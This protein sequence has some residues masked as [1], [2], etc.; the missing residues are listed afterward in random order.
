MATSTQKERVSFAQLPQLDGLRAICLLSIVI[1]HWTVHYIKIEF[2]FEIGAFVFF[3]LSG[4]LITRILL[5]GKEKI[6]LGQSSFSILL[7]TFTIRRVLRLLPGYYLALLLYVILLTP[8]V[9]QN[10][11][12]YVTNSTNIHFA[13]MG[14]WAG[15]ADQFWTLAV[16]QQ[17]YAILP[18]IVLLVPNR[19]LP[20]VFIIIAGL[21]PLSRFMTYFDNP[22]FTGPKHDKL[23]WFLTDHLC[24]G[25]LLAYFHE[26]GKLPR[27]LILWTVLV[28]SLMLFI[29]MRYHL[30]IFEN[31]GKVFI[32]Q[33]TV[34]ATF[35][36]CLVA[37]C[38]KGIG[39]LGKVVLEHP[40]I[41]YVGKRSYGYYL[42]HNLAFLLLGKTFFFLFPT[43]AE[44]DPFFILR[45]ILAS[46]ILYFMTHFSWKYVEEPL[47][48][49]K[50]KHRYLKAN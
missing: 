24:F 25:A 19:F 18:F 44:P 21:S 22:L 23:P 13:L 31:A 45:I 50:Q 5:R 15:G 14:K 4:Y 41:Q 33:Q 3:A 10:F 17:F 11:I 48:R 40:V 28:C 47:M 38:T 1:H 46:V 49:R 43:E 42:Y 34:L 36:T 27:K 20:Y 37:L 29:L 8:D 30:L 7:K 6:A 2:P 35:S 32:W 12:W 16:D 9:L 26:K 39:G